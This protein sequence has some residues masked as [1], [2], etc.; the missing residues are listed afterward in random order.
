MAADG[1]RRRARA[2]A[3]LDSEFGG[4][5]EPVQLGFPAPAVGLAEDV[6]QKQQQQ[7]ADF[8]KKPERFP[9]SL[10][11]FVKALETHLCSSFQ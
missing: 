2:Q 5:E 9:Y 4:G 3:P 11:Y 1:S 7:S 8:S 10:K 6:L